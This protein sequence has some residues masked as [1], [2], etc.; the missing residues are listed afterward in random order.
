[1]MDTVRLWQGRLLLPNAPF[2][3]HLEVLSMAL[4]PG[5]FQEFRRNARVGFLHTGVIVEN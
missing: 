1:M 5:T 2:N 4:L 3:S